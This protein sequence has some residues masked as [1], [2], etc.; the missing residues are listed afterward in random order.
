M[1]PPLTSFKSS[2]PFDKPLVTRPDCNLLILFP[3][4]LGPSR[5]RC[6]GPRNCGAPDASSKVH[7]MSPT[8][9]SAFQVNIFH[10]CSQESITAAMPGLTTYASIAALAAFA[11][12]VAP[13]VRHD[14]KVVG[15]GRSVPETTIPNA[16]D[17]NKIEDTVHCEDMHHYL[18]ADVLFAAC[19]DRR[20]RFDWFPPLHNFEPPAEGTQGSFHVIDPK[21]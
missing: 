8:S 3:E 12:Y 9:S 5:F 14:M 18:P 16:L 20:T 19:E 10:S 17:Y 2:R 11:T 13:S 7:S 1:C 6:P 15:V 21:V 4:E